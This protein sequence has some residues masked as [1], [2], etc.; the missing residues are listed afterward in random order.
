[1]VAALVFLPAALRLLKSRRRQAGEPHVL[2]LPV[3]RAFRAA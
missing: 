3:E 1:M 2:P